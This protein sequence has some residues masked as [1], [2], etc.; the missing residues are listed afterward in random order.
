M[1]AGGAVGQGE[2][3]KGTGSSPRVGSSPFPLGKAVKAQP[4]QFHS[5]PQV[6]PPGELFRAVSL[7]RKV[8]EGFQEPRQGLL[9]DRC[10]CGD[11]A[12]RK[13]R[14][15]AGTGLLCQ[16]VMLKQGSQNPRA[17]GASPSPRVPVH[18]LRAGRRVAGMSP[19]TKSSPVSGLCRGDAICPSV[20]AGW[21]PGRPSRPCRAGC[22]CTP[23]P[24]PRE[25][26][27]CG[28]WCPS[29]S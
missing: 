28:S 4:H 3:Q 29:R 2:L 19:R 26:T 15:G 12:P 24:R 20:F 16:P 23:T 17:A 13:F 1:R 22:T 11:T 21:W 14:V 10:Q 18:P 25:P 6:L 9:L 8:F 27:G 7:C 5:C